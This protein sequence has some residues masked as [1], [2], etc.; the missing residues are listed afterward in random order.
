MNSAASRKVT[1]DENSRPWP[2]LGVRD[3]GPKPRQAGLTLT[4]DPGLGARGL[5]LAVES[6]HEFI[7]IIKF[8]NVTPALFTLAQLQDKLRLLRDRQIA[9]M[10][11]GVLL[12]WAFAHNIVDRVIEATAEYGFGV[13]EISDGILPISDDQQAR[14]AASVS[15]AGMRVVMEWGRKWPDRLA[16]PATVAN[17]VKARIDMGAELVVLEE[18]ELDL[19]FALAPDARTDWFGEF[20]THVDSNRVTFEAPDRDH[21]ALLIQH[22]GSEVNL[23]PNLDLD[24]VLWVEPMRR[25]L[26]KQV[27]YDALQGVTNE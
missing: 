18:S 11:G 22:F 25:G 6:C 10:T 17:A 12:E 7:D 19:V 5:D 24:D 14:M 9:A 8:R 27:G 2:F 16:A 1:M 13:M 26:G 3:R 15:S 23:G 21:Q 20:Q 4:R